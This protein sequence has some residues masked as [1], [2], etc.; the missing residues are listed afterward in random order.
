VTA[1]AAI[2]MFTGDYLTSLASERVLLRLR[3]AVFAHAQELPPDFFDKRRLGDLV[4]RLFDDVAIIE[5]LIASGLVGTRPLMMPCTD[6]V[7]PSSRSLL[8]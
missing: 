7:R 3:D 8:R 1:A 2:A 4:V 5:G 6:G